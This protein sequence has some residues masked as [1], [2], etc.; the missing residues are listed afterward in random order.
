M[1]IYLLACMF[2]YLLT[3]LLIHLLIHLLACLL[4]YLLALTHSLTLSLIFLP[5]VGDG[6]ALDQGDSGEPDQGIAVVYSEGDDSAVLAGT[7]G[8]DWAGAFA[9]G[10]LDF[11]AVKVDPDGQGKWRWQASVIF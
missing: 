7:T 4:A 11:A 8:G 6:F 3:D 1:P 10:S 2:N 5:G 9:G